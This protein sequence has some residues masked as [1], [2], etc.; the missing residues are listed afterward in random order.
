MTL[1]EPT[2]A[3]SG[4]AARRAAR[5]SGPSAV[6]VPYIQRDIP[7]FDVLGEEGLLRIERA[8]DRLLAETGLDFR[9]DPE[10]LNLW[11]KAGARVDGDRVRFE[12]GM[13]REILKTAPREFTQH[14]RNP[15]NSVRIGGNNLVMAPSYGSPFVMDLDNGRRF[16]TLQDF[17]NFIKLGQSSPWLHHSGGT[18]CEPTD[19]A[20]NKRHLDMIYA[21]IR[22]SDRAF[23]GSVTAEERAEDSIDMARI[24]FG[25]AFVA[26]NC[27][28]M[29][30][31]NAN[32]PLMWDGTMTK[33][34]RA[35]ARA[36]QA[37]VLVPFILGGAM[38]PVTTAGAIAQAMAEA[39]AGCA[40][41][42]LERPG[43][44]VVL[45][46]FLSSMSLRS[47]SPTFGTPEPAIGSM[48]VGQ[49]TRRL[50][51]PLRCAGNFTNSKLPDAQAMMEGTMSMLSAV[52]C[53]SNF[54]LHSAG[55][56]DGL[57]SM[58]YEKFVMDC[59]LA[60]AIHAYCRGVVVDDN[61]LAEDAFAEVGPGNHF[62]GC[63]HTLANYETAFWDSELS[64][65]EPYEK[66]D[67]NGRDDHATRA[68]RL[69]KRRLAAYTAPALDEGTDEALRDFM[70]RKKA[71]MPDQWY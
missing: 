68:N 47:G 25:E 30:N 17:E 1:A 61:T 40:L 4:R 71:E 10:S 49:L 23:M 43:A 67:L 50:G 5:G 45:G 33:G 62:F 13:L 66:W 15:A 19:I 63:A 6:G 57:L 21:H 20:V 36:G 3:R 26:E 18:I 69:W 52:Q 7:T 70:A 12:P 65:N 22:Y 27:V 31:F 28:I 24:L 51:L 39:M 32:S 46:N 16:G 60:G 44:P 59:D 64:D 41:A 11:R 35:Y 54:T 55:F 42:Q 48:V 38:G 9:D 14:A 2:R 29:G 58:S 34:L 8:I 53:G 56:L 37:T